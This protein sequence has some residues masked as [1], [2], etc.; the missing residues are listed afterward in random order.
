MQIG[1]EDLLKVSDKNTKMFELQQFQRVQL[2][3]FWV[4]VLRNLLPPFSRQ[5]T[6]TAGSP[7]H[8]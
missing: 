3:A 8:W 7:K 2:T 4:M 5:K 6:V 1:K